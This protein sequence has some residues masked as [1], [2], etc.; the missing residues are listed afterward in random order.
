[1]PGAEKLSPD[2]LDLLTERAMHDTQPRAD[3]LRRCDEL[4]AR[5]EALTSPAQ[6]AESAR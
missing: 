5:L 2:E 1:M 6:G 3:L 4:Q